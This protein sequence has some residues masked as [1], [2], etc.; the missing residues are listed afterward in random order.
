MSNELRVKLSLDKTEADKGLD[1]FERK[2]SKATDRARDG[3]GRFAKSTGE[4]SKEVEGLG[5][6]I[7]RAGGELA[8]LIKA[9]MGLGAIKGIAQAIGSEWNRIADE[10]GKASREWQ[11]FRQ[12]LQGIAALEGKGNTNAFAASEVDRAERAR[13]TPQEARQFR[14]AFLAK[15]SL[16][17]GE[18]AN[19]KLS[20]KDADELQVALMEYAKDKGVSQEEMAGFAGGLLAQEK[21]KTSAAAMKEK[22]GKVFATLEAS[23]APVAHLLP[24]MT[25][26]Q[27]QG[28]SAEEASQTLAMMPEI[29]PEE[30]GTYLLRAVSALRERVQK[31]EGGK[32]GLKK[33]MTPYQI[34]TTAVSNIR[35]RQAK[36][37]DL[38]DLLT[39]ATGGEEVSGKALRGLVNQGPEGFARWRGVMDKVSKTQLQD[40]ILAERKTESGRQRHVDSVLAAERARLGIRND[41]VERRRQIAEAELLKGGELERV[42]WG[43]AIGGYLPRAIGGTDLKASLINQQAIRRARAELGEGMGVKDKFISTNQGATD[44]LLR[45][46]I[47][48]IEHQTETIKRGQ[49]SPGRA[50]APIPSRPAVTSPRP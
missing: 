50:P 44:E 45:E 1:A 38:D 32:F 22:A 6:S 14:E 47:K 24:M 30:E 42:N 29:A 4:A 35:A 15:A 48:R 19:A 5:S 28:F 12:S 10:I 21:G 33:G 37:E 11:Q 23:S 31:G 36:G 13:V 9:Q 17:V 40:T 41:T 34:L 27:A 3:M 49:Q 18:G 39:A 20:S 7:G 2:A 25:R 43:Q 46:L 26:A 16:Y 8:T